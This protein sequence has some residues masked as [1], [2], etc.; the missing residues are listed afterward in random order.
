MNV[1]TVVCLEE[2]IDK[3]CSTFDDKKSDYNLDDIIDDMA[4]VEVVHDQEDESED[5]ESMR[6]V[7]SSD[8]E[9]QSQAD[10]VLKLIAEARSQYVG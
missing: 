5:L 4:D 6:R 9:I 2:D 1:E 3:V 8:P 7:T 10:Q